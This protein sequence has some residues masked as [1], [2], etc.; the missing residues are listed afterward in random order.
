MNTGHTLILGA[1]DGLSASLARRF[2]QAQGDIS[3]V[4]RD[5]QKLSLLCGQIGAKAYA[6]DVTD[7]QAVKRLFT[8]LD[9]RN[10]RLQNVIYNVGA[11]TR[12]A[13]DQVDLNDAK[14]ALLTNAFG[15]MIVAQEASKRMVK[16][17]AGTL[18]FTGASAG[19]KGFAQSS[20]FAMGKFA[21]RGLCQSLARELAP[22][23][24]HVAHFII[25]GLIYSQIRG[26]PYDN[27]DS[28]L[29]PDHI[30]EAYFSV[31]NQHKSCWTYEMELRPFNE[32]F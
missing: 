22:Q 1:G 26:T 2:S 3:L 7:Q 10:I 8:D 25:D 15:A 9:K 24:I 19:V 5:S 12:G 27:P 23:G 11:Y 18:L 32:S 16:N 21:L 13:I 28:T 17:G 31:A 6:C 14:Q 29:N 30:A 20:P 4:A